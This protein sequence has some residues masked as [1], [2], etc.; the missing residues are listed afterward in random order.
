MGK[1]LSGELSCPC[2]RSCLPSSQYGST[3]KGKNLLLRSKFF[4][5]RVDKFWKGFSTRE[6]NRKLQK[7]SPSGIMT[8][9]ACESTLIFNFQGLL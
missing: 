5:L 3:L 9:K 6:A 4:P 1:A 7:G 8:E 2:D